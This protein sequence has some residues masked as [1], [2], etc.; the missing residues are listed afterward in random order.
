MFLKILRESER[1][2]LR[3]REKNEERRRK[4]EKK[5]DRGRQGERE[6]D[7]QEHVVKNNLKKKCVAIFDSPLRDYRDLAQC[8]SDVVI[9]NILLMKAL[10]VTNEHLGN[11][12]TT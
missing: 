6:R 8:F 2:R 4:K 3:G 12:F 10:L 7:T 11:S 9:R 5:K 1:V